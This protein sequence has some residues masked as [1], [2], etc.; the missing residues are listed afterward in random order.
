MSLNLMIED[1]LRSI[2]NFFKEKSQ[3]DTYMVYVMLIAVMA[4]VA[5]PFYDLS[6][7]EFNKVKDNIAEIK[8]KINADKVYLKVNTEA[9]IVKL[10]QKIKELENELQVNKDNNQYIKH[11]IETI[12]SLIYDER[13][14]GEY[15]N[16]ISVKAKKHGIKIINFTN[17]YT[18]SN[19]S[20]GHVL[21]IMLE[22]SGNYSNT[23]KFINSIEQSELVVDL[24]D[25]SMKTQDR[26]NTKLKISVWGITY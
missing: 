2:D 12:S 17:K 5:Y 3:K 21:D 22:V 19:N 1:A 11:K 23:V 14:W 8:V 13:T 4:T 10:N 16:S 25:L 26:L 9:K 7:N 20:F 15:L 24:H 6:V 18:D